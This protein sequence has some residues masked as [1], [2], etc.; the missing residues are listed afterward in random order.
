MEGKG[1]LMPPPRLP[2][3][4]WARHHSRCV[5]CGTRAVRHH[6]HGRCRSCQSKRQAPRKWPAWLDGCLR[7]ETPKGEATYRRR[8][9]CGPC[10][11]IVTVK[12]QAGPWAVKFELAKSGRRSRKGAVACVQVLQL[13]RKFGAPDVAG[14]IGV[15]VDRVRAWASGDEDV[16]PAHRKAVED[17]WLGCQS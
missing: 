11:R 10:E 3:G 12:R 13:C 14:I 4:R 15:A 7:C 5:D 16:P 6:S 8:G 9:L 1:E 17:A 2:A